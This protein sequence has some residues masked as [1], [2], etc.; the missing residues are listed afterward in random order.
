MGL[1]LYPY[2]DIQ[3]LLWEIEVVWR[4]RSNPENPFRWESVRLNR[5]GDI[6]YYPMIE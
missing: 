5:K 1:M 2:A 4:E 3:G 6:Y